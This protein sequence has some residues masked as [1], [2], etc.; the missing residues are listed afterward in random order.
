VNR[1]I[2]VEKSKYR[3]QWRPTIYRS[4]GVTWPTFEILGPPPYLG[5]G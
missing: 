4:E 1:Q 3:G 5:N 2:G